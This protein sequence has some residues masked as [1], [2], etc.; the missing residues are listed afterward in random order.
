MPRAV[1]GIPR[2]DMMMSRI[3]IEALGT[4]GTAR[5][6]IVVRILK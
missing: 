6:D 2:L 5:V 3:T 1:A 4:G